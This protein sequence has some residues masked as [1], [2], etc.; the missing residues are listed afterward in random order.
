MACNAPI[1]IRRR[2]AE[3]CSLKCLLF[4]KYGNSS[5]TVRNTSDQLLIPYDGENDVMFNSVSY[6][7]VEVR[8]FKPSI[9]QFEGS[10]TEAEIVIV[11][12]GPNGGLLVCIPVNAT[13]SV[14]AS[15]GAKLFEDIVAS[16]PEQ[17]VSSTLNI[18]DFNL[19]HMIPKS[20]YFSYTGTVPYGTCNPDVMYSY[21]VF[22]LNSFQVHQDTLD[23]LGDLI[24]DSYIQIYDGTCYWNEMGTKN[25]GFAGE[26]QIYIDC[27]PVG[28]EG[29]II[30]KEQ[31]AP[32]KK[33][34][35]EWIYAFLYVI[36]GAVIMYWGAKLFRFMLSLLP[37][38][39]AVIEES[40]A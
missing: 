24:H 4:Y 26:G 25:N 15:T 35:L 8:I 29:E 32:G 27:Q 21:V 19:N 37:D 10:Y 23:A 33:V 30:Y 31:S 9:H 2:L 34:N 38:A 16:S 13:T 40:N 18:T 11:H 14:A 20:S 28:E 3:K 6:N 7:P 22:P 5:C 1:N 39:D 17:D 12:T 36:I